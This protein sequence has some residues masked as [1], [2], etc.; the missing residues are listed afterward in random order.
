MG[1]ALG[2][3]AIISQARETLEEVAATSITSIN[4]TRNLRTI[5][6][7]TSKHNLM[8]SRNPGKASSSGTLKPR[9]RQNGISSDFYGTACFPSSR[10]TRQTQS[11]RLEKIRLSLTHITAS[12]KSPRCIY[13]FSTLH[14]IMSPPYW[15]PLVEMATYIFFQQRVINKNRYGKR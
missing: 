4:G 1:L 8:C 3:R 2:T 5:P 15:N 9:A 7:N 11:A 14:R 13:N 12:S 6:G 10:T